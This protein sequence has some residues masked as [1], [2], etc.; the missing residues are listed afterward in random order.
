MY[1][2]VLLVVS[3]LLC[4]ALSGCFDAYA[5]S[6]GIGSTQFV[7]KNTLDVN[8]SMAIGTYAGIFSAPAG[9]SLIISNNVGIGTDAPVAQLHTTGTV[10]FANYTNGLLSVD[11]SGNLV[12]G[13]TIYGWLTTGNT[14]TTAGTNFIGTTDLKDFIFKTGGSA[15]AN[16]RMRILS[17]GNVGIGTTTPAQLLDVGGNIQS[18]ASTVNTPIQLSLTAGMPYMESIYVK[19]RFLYGVNNGSP[20]QLYV[21]DVTNPAAPV[22]DATLN[23]GQKNRFVQVFAQ[24]A[25]I[26][27]ENEGDLAIVD[28]SNPKNPIGV[29]DTYLGGGDIR[30]LIV[31]GHYVYI[32]N[33]DGSIYIVD[34][35]NPASPLIVSNTTEPLGNPMDVVVQGKYLYIA[36]DGSGLVIMDISNPAVVT[37][38]GILTLSGTAPV[39]IYMTGH[40]AY[41]GDL[42]TGNV[43]IIDVS[44]VTAPV[45]VATVNVGSYVQRIT[46][47][48]RYLYTSGANFDIVDIST[49]ASPVVMY[50]TVTNNYTGICGEGRYI[51]CQDAN[52]DLLIY[53]IKGIEVSGI[54]SAMGD[55]GQL[56]VQNDITAL[57]TIQA[58]SG[59]SVGA[60]GLFSSGGIGTSG[61]T[62]LN[63][64][65][66]LE[67]RTTATNY[68]VLATDY[69]IGVTN[70]S[71]ARIIT[72][73]ASAASGN[74]K[75]VIIKDES[76]GAGGNNITV[77]GNGTDQIDGASSKTINSNYG[78]LRLICSGTGWF[79]Y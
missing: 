23:Y 16:E 56:Q 78:S 8:G 5:Q 17:S 39:T 75:V 60:G 18:I 22:L 76:G 38:V 50:S 58:T 28:V 66:S 13:S 68:T 53:D 12:V 27:S 42:N 51:Y 52:N 15:S 74:G 6:V 26:T 20:G 1:R 65:L 34:V 3:A 70:T 73:P 54:K 67:R 55:F 64:G 10:R 11:G 40:Y 24:Y 71:S 7:P 61:L 32:A 29:S 14:G 47:S 9:T 49:P 72:L 31:Q 79:S 37:T 44:N 21:I 45:Q 69:Y 2:H 46:C 30:K 63:G 48:G 43:L 36:D 77:A 19:G 35:S 59:I 33:H 62:T 4:N 57:G 25:Y 41:V